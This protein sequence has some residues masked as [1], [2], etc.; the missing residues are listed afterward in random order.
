[1]RTVAE[2]IAELTK[3]PADAFVSQVMQL[4]ENQADTP[5]GWRK[6]TVPARIAALVHAFAERTQPLPVELAQRMLRILDRL[7]D[8][9]DRRSAALQQSEIFKAVRV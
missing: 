3:Y 9:G 7:V 1:M 8:M 5:V 6:S 2:L 4:L